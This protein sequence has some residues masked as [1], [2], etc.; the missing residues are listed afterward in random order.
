VATFLNVTHDI[1]D[2]SA[3]TD[4]T[5]ERL[6]LYNLH[7]FDDLTARIPT[8]RAALHH[9][10]IERWISENPPAK[11]PGWE[12]YP[13]SLR[14]SNWIKAELARGPMD[15]RLL[16]QRALQSLAVQVRW[17]DQRLEF[18]I[19]GNHLLA[20]V[21][22][23][24]MAGSF[25]SGPEASRWKTRAV[26][27]LDR[28]LRD[29]VLSDGGHFERSPMYHAVVVEDFLDL[30]QLSLVF[31]GSLAP[32]LADELRRTVTRMLRWLHVMSHPDGQISFF[33]DAAFGIAASYAELARYA[34]QLG[35]DVDD[36]PLTPVE[37]LPASGYVRLETPRAT[38]LCDI[39]PVG[40]DHQ[41]GHAHADTLS[42]ELS[43]DG[44][45]VIVNGGTSTYASGAARAKERGTSAHSTVEVD[46]V[47]STE[48]WA[49]FRVARRARPSAVRCGSHSDGGW[50]EGAHDGYLRLPGRVMHWRRWDLDSKGL[51]VTDTLTGQFGEAVARFLLAPISGADTPHITISTTSPMAGARERAEWHPRFGVSVDTVA[52]VF[53]MRHELTTRVA[54]V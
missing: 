54:W 42:F 29:Q 21:K 27:L 32:E 15:E 22:A 24:L 14:I 36:R 8:D 10:L 20:N 9:E 41:P 12:P 6:W 31:P 23:L 16:S 33:N 48:V 5:R 13:T 47:D 1:S 44:Q 43:V 37:V 11:G 25:F 26:R 52:M 28:E 53:P 17:L 34:R 19:L 3:W 49:S 40:P 7:Y 18:H 46:G 38:V 51:T 50:V 2:P 45:R 39:A 30:V 4:P 35:V